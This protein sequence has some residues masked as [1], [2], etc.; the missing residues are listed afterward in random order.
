V[1]C[2]LPKREKQAHEI[3]DLRRGGLVDC[4]PPTLSLLGSCSLM[5]RI[6][7]PK[8]QRTQGLRVA[9]V[10][11]LTPCSTFWVDGEIFAVLRSWGFDHA[12]Y[13]GHPMIL[14][15]RGV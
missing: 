11:R 5:R 4:W 6:S 15:I 12:M 14:F 2:R 1:V 3:Y 8:G 13:N 10:P 9:T 7:T